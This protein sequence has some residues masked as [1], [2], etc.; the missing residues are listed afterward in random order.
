MKKN[1]FKIT[2]FTFILFTLIS[3]SNST[4]DADEGPYPWGNF[5]EQLTYETIVGKW[6]LIAAGMTETGQHGIR[7][8][9]KDGMYTEYLSDATLRVYDPFFY[10][11]HFVSMGKYEIY[12]DS[13][14]KYN[15]NNEFVYSPDDLHSKACYQYGLS[16]NLLKLRSLRIDDYQLPDPPVFSLEF[17]S[18]DR[19][20][21]YQ[22]IK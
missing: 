14:V 20:F 6:E 21:I 11:G 22:R 17:R 2:Y 4:N 9:N 19:I 1:Y 13:L 16:G 5:N 12:P 7:S 18:Q 10:G 15:G 3:C 8:V